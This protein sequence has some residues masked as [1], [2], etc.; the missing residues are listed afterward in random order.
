MRATIRLLVCAPFAVACARDA[1]ART[2]TV[3]P[4]G[5]F[6]RISDAGI[7]GTLDAINAAEVAAGQLATTKASSADVRAFA[8]QV[9][10]DHGA[11]RDSLAA[12]SRTSRI[13]AEETLDARA[14]AARGRSL[15]D[16]LATLSG[17]AFDLTYVDAQVNDH[18][19]ALQSLTAWQSYAADARIRAQ[20]RVARPV[21]QAHYDHALALLSPLIPAGEPSVWKKHLGQPTEASGKPTTP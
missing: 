7:L 16:T 19:M 3:Q 17:P 14:I 5:N 15:L 8:D 11:M 20:L 13:A 2:D 18:Q 4:Q 1:A 9:I 21:V 6:T 10:R 12:V